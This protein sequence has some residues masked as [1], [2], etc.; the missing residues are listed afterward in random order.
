MV[1]SVFDYPAMQKTADDLI[2]YFGMRAVLRRVNS[3]PTDRFVTIA[4]IEDKPREK[5]NE[6][7]NPEDR[8]VVMSPLDPDTG[9]VLAIPPDNEQDVLVTFVQPMTNP[10]IMKEV[11]R[12]TATPKQTAPADVNCLWEFTVR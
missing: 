5:P 10:P 7:A 11:L 12:L 1:A 6:L 2:K 8:D 9:L 4:I 3:S